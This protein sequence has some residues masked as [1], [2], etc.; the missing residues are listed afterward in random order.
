MK[1]ERR[2]E[3]EFVCVLGNDEM[4]SLIGKDIN[5]AL[6]S[7]TTIDLLVRETITKLC[8]EY[9]LDTSVY[10]IGTM[11]YRQNDVDIVLVINVVPTDSEIFPDKEDDDEMEEESEEMY[12]SAPSKRNQTRVNGSPA[13][14]VPDIE[15]VINLQLNYGAFDLSA[16]AL[17]SFKGKLV[18]ALDG[19][20]SLDV[21]VCEDLYSLFSEYAVKTYDLTR[22]YLDE[23]G[24]IITTNVPQLVDIL[25]N[26]KDS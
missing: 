20:D 13:F 19:Q 10:D 22:S 9:N 21:E 8:A 17:Y 26:K 18:I 11:I 12:A 25:T 15:H 16:H 1:F 14:M 3:S 4:T 2:S 7:S 6:E 23:Y 5:S 24:K